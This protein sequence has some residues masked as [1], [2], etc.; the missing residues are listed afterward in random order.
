MTTWCSRFVRNL[1]LTCMIS[2]NKDM[3]VKN[4][5][6]TDRFFCVLSNLIF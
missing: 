5:S 6:E 2:Y 1:P 3:R 4:G